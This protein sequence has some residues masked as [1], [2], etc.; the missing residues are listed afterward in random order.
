MEHTESRR[1]RGRPRQFDLDE[2][3]AA[4]Q[5][6]FHARGYDA[7]SVADLTQAIGINPPSFYAAFGSK[8]D[9]FSRIL[10]RY[11]AQDA[12]PLPDLLSADRPI[13]ECLVALEEAARRYA[14]DPGA[15]GCLVIEGARCADREAKGAA[16]A[17]ITAAEEAIYR[18]I[19]PLRYPDQ[20][21]CIQDY[22]STVMAKRSPAPVTGTILIAC[23][24]PP[25]SQ[26][27]VLNRRS[28]LIGKV[29]KS[30]HD[31]PVKEPLMGQSGRRRYPRRPRGLPFSRNLFPIVFSQ[32]SPLHSLL[33]RLAHR[34]RSKLRRMPNSGFPDGHA[35]LLYAA[36]HLDQ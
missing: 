24:Q 34:E 17:F 1:T 16:G 22:M 25:V 23:S 31:V 8:A 26:E 19:K 33:L 4:A 6:L 21:A 11:A 36:R 13:A 9:P 12:I 30:E 3:V 15:A 7:V 32:N 5:R 20:A 28:R 10:D 18:F 27:S 35:V 14:A 2:A 29:G